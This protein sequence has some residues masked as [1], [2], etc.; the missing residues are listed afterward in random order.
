MTMNQPTKPQITITKNMKKQDVSDI[1]E[2]IRRQQGD[3]RHIEARTPREFEILTED[4]K[5]YIEEYNLQA[6]EEADTREYQWTIDAYIH[7]RVGDAYMATFQHLLS[8]KPFDINPQDTMERLRDK[9]TVWQWKVRQRRDQVRQRIQ[10]KMRQNQ[11]QTV[12]KTP[13]KTPTKNCGET[14]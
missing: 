6:D 1:L 9:P 5:L 3:F 2:D 7:C 8:T 10:Q 14:V 12:T 13:D 4:L 11:S